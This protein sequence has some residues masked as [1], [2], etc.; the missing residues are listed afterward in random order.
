MVRDLEGRGSEDGWPGSV[1]RGYVDGPLLT[2]T[3][4]GDWMPTGL[5]VL[6]H[7]KRDACTAGDVARHSFIVP[8]IA[9]D[10]SH[11]FSFSAYGA[12]ASTTV[13]GFTEYLTLRPGILYCIASA[14]SELHNKDRVEWAY[15]LGIY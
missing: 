15:V 5:C 7:R 9:T 14:W 13:R 11:K 6:P 2:S 8:G 3:G 12:S 4:G 10:S 1:G